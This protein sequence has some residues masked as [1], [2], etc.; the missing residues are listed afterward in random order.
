MKKSK[1]HRMNNRESTDKEIYRIQKIETEKR[2]RDKDF[3]K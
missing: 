2:A 1:V 3:M